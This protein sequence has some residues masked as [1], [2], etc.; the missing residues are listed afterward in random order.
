MKPLNLNYWTGIAGVGFFI[1]NMTIIPLYFVYYGPP[2]E[3]NI[4]TRSLIGTFA[5]LG[6]IFFVT[7]FRSIILKA[8]SEDEFYGRSF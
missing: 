6:L 4:L 8:N 7:G 1:L 2:P 5:C 3:W